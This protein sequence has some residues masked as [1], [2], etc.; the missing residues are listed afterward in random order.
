MLMK[1]KVVDDKKKDEMLNYIVELK[2][3]S[4]ASL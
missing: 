2:K 1:S 3:Y 4:P